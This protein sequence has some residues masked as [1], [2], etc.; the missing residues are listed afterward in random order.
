LSGP[1]GKTGDSGGV[2]DYAID[3]HELRKSFGDHAAVDGIDLSVSKGEIFGFLGPNGAGKSTTIRMLCG[4]LQPTSGEG[5]VAG[6]DI[7]R[8]P[9]NIKKVIGYMS[10]H[11]GLYTDLTVEENI[12]F[13]SGIYLGRRS[14]EIKEQMIE[15]M[16]LAK[17]RKFLAGRLSGGWKQRLALACAISHSPRVLFL[18]EPTAG[19]DPMSR[20][21]LW[22]FLYE[23][24]EQGVTLFVTT[25][26]MDE[27]EYCHR[28]G[29]IMDGKLTA[30]AAP[31][32]IKRHRMKGDVITLR[33]SNN[34]AAFEALK[35]SPLLID[36]NVYGDSIHLV[37]GSADRAMDSVRRALSESGIEVLEMRES[38]PTIEDVFVSLSKEAYG[39]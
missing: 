4:L 39:T 25:H 11:F 36:V 1:S 33:C 16:G 31:N 22:D 6:H 38:E 7:I 3:V 20:R 23:K 28:L 2:G 19:I 9:E 30:C 13:Y 27:A 24:S 32:E 35:G 15:E 17:Y 29:F 8:E 5:H 12:E 26:Y 18:D 34:T 10:Q 21:T 14:K 37:A